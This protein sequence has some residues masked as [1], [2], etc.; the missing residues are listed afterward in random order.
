[1]RNHGVSCG[2]WRVAPE[3]EKWPQKALDMVANVRAV[4]SAKGM[5]YYGNTETVAMF[6]VGV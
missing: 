2:A 4:S 5:N 3:H 6:D 1:M